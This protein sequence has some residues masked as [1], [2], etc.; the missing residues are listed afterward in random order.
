MH[1]AAA[2]PM[3]LKWLIEDGKE[4]GPVNMQGGRPAHD[5]LQQYC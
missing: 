4:D 2:L 5:D 1:L 3:I